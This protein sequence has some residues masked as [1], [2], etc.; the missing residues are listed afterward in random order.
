M[1]FIVPFIPLIA[2]AA[3]LAGTIYNQVSQPSSGDIQKQQQ[4]QL[5]QQQAAQ[6]KQ[7]V[8]AAQSSIQPTMSNLQ[9]NLGGA[10]SPEYYAQVA[11]TLSGFGDLSGR[12]GMPLAN[13]FFG[14]G[15][16]LV[17]GGLDQG[18]QQGGPGTLGLGSPSFT[19][20]IANMG[21]GQ[22]SLPPALAQLM[23]QGGGGAGMQ[24]PP[25]L[26][27]GGFNGG[28]VS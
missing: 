15:S 9:A 3:G 21:N 13:S 28:T 23:Q 20:Q 12:V 14:L 22:S 4:E 24:L 6:D 26:F 2:A 10:V 8:Q 18:G 19:S 7:R 5:A 17:P 1:P 16:G 11:S 27:G 25:G